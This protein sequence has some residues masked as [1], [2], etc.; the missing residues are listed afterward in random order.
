MS[1]DFQIT[2]FVFANADSI[3]SVSDTL[4]LWLLL[5]WLKTHSKVKEEWR[6]L[7]RCMN[8]VVILEFYQ[9]QQIILATLLFTYKELEILVKFL[10]N[11]FC[12]TIVNAK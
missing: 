1:C 10:L 11:M 9:Q 8:M 12:L 7:S 6:L 4:Q 5:V 2:D 3:C